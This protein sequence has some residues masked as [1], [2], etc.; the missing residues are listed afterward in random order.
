[1]KSQFTDEYT[2]SKCLSQLGGECLHNIVPSCSMTDFDISEIAAFKNT[3]PNIVPL[4]CSFYAVTRQNKC[5]DRNVPKV[6]REKLK[7]KFK[8]L[9]FVGGEQSLKRKM[10][11]LKRYCTVNRL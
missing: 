5:I 7:A 9:H 4:I 1:M 3:W 11:N 6:H 8:E 2:Y 10:A